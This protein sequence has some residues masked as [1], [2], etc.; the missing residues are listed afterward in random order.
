MPSNF[1]RFRFVVLLGACA[2]C[3]CANVMRRATSQFADN[4]TTAILNED[5]PGTV[6]D[7]VPAYLLLVDGMI[8]GDPENVGALM[9][10]AKLYDSYAGGFVED[11]VR[12]RRLAE[13]AYGYAKRALCLRDKE[14]CTALDAPFDAFQLALAKTKADNLDV[15]YGFASAWASRIQVN[16]GDWNAIADLPKLQSL[17]LHVVSLDA[18]YD[19]GGAYLYL[20]VINSIRPASLGGKPEVGKEYFDK[21]LELSAGRNQ[22]VRVLYAQFYAR[23]VFDQALH[24]KLLNEVLAADPVAPKLTLINTLA[25]RKA[26]AL[27]ESGKDYF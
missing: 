23:L 8:Q 4:L 14:L 16:T 18:H 6:R 5:D 10:G 24:D 3:A 2:L 26:K 9:A 17:L 12:A 20:G 19:D 11:D 1:S 15:L 7:G 21:A 27:L 25:Q 22:M 13:R